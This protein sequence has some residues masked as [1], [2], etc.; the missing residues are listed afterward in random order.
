MMHYFQDMRLFCAGAL[1]PAALL[2]GAAARTGPALPPQVSDSYGK[3][4][5]SFE[6]NRGQTD[7]QVKFLARGSGYTLFLTG[8]A[9]V[10]SLRR[11]KTNAVLRMKLRAPTRMPA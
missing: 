10:L 11:E 3:L 4:P 8:D 5:L 2:M 7:R 6:A 1:L 9:A